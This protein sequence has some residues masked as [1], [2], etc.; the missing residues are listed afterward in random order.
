MHPDAYPILAA[1]GEAELRVKESRFLALARPVESLARAD[2][3]RA[4]LARRHPDASHLCWALRL[5]PPAAA[6]CRHSDAG[7]PAGSAGPPIARA[8]VSADLFD[9]ACFVLRWFG[10]TKLG[11]GGL[12]RA[13][14]EAA[15]A[16]LASARRGL[17]LALV[18]IEGETSY[19]LEAPLRAL[20]ARCN[21]RIHGRECRER[22][23]W[24][25]ALP[26]SDLAEF[27]AHCQ[28]LAQGRELFRRVVGDEPE[29][30]G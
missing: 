2:E 30:S 18:E 4:E 27:T 24:R 29:R 28:G 21:G 15:R 13:Y 8:L 3:L 14:G 26:P 17:R 16:S 22:I 19:E 11:V 5:G 12:I 20:L 25:L 9:L 6:S 7:E 10:G 1:G 23:R